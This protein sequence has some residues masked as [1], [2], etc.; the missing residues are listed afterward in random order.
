MKKTI[1]SLAVP[2][3]LFSGQVLSQTIVSSDDG[4]HLNLYGRVQADFRDRGNGATTVGGA[5]NE[6]NANRQ[7]AR[8]GFSGRQA[9]ENGMAVIGQAEYQLNNGDG[10]TNDS[11]IGSTDKVDWV[12]R[13]VWAGVD[14]NELGRVE[15]GRV[16][17][18][19][20]MFTSIGDVFYSGGDPVAGYHV[21]TVDTSADL[22]FRQNG[23]LQYK[24][25]LGNLD[26]ATA[27]I[28]NSSIDSGYNFAASYNVAF[29]S[30][31][32]S[33]IGMY[34]LNKNEE[35][36]AN[37]EVSK[38]QTYGI[39]LRYFVEDLYFG[40]GYSIEDMD[41][42]N[43][44]KDA[45]TKGGDIVMTYDFGQWIARAGYRYLAFDEV[46]NGSDDVIENTWIAEAQYKLTPQ[47]SL[48]VNYSDNSGGYSNFS[49]GNVEVVGKKGSLASFGFRWTF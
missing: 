33:L 21:N 18:G 12:A 40:A 38:Y 8:F 31:K 39:G 48:F 37:V 42:Y 17:S 47:S 10:N 49:G 27:Y 24:N 35:K 30:S 3:L 45:K 25:S 5:D 26:F 11:G 22:V 2:T 29:D 6:V 19:L 13:Y 32:L 9:M 23:T 41:L 7:Y 20:L 14:M 46:S 44:S 34:Q 4:S 36:N 16:A 1:L 28:Q 15:A 43:S